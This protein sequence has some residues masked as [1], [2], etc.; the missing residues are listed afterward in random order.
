M[1]L[2]VG[3]QEALQ[4]VLAPLRCKARVALETEG[5]FGVDLKL[6]G[7]CFERRV[8]QR[9]RGLQAA[10]AEA[11]GCAL[12]HTS[13]DFLGRHGLAHLVKGSLLRAPWH[14]VRLVVFHEREHVKGWN[15]GRC[16]W[17]VSLV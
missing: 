2:D 16:P 9:R 8:R 14:Q 17:S 12:P 1:R 13:G 3:W 7:A 11:S 6:R 5:L 10:F 4:L 15:V